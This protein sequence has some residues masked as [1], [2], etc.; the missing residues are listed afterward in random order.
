MTAAPASSVLMVTASMRFA[1]NQDS[2]GTA[3]PERTAPHPAKILLRRVALIYLYLY[4]VL[5]APL[6]L[7]LL[8]LHLLQLLH[9]LL[10]LF[11]LFLQQSCFLT[12]RFQQLFLF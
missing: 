5:P 1:L 10:L 9:L 12:F 6:H 8:L 4:R 2:A 11:N 7:L 3:P